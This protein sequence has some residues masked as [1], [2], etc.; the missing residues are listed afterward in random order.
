[1]AFERKWNGGE[2]I[3]A[4][5]IHHAAAGSLAG[6]DRR[7]DRRSRSPRAPPGPRWAAA[8]AQGSGA[9]ASG[10]ASGAAVGNP[11]DETAGPQGGLLA[12]RIVYFDFDSSDIKGE[13]TDV[14]AAH[15]KYLGTN[16]SARIRL[17]GHTDERGSP[18]YN[19]G[20]GERRAQAVRRALL[21][22]GATDVQ[23]T[24]VSYGEERPAVAGHDEAAWAK[25]RRVEIIYLTPAAVPQVTGTGSTRMQ[26]ALI[27]LVPLV[28]AA[29]CATT[30]PEE[31]PLQIKINDLEARTERLERS[32]ANQ[33][34]TAAHTEEIDAQLRELRGRIEELEH[35]A[36]VATKLA[37]GCGPRTGA[38]AVAG[39]A[40][41]G[42]RRT[43]PAARRSSRPPP[44]R[45]STRRPTMRS[46][47]AA[48]RSRSP[49][50]RTS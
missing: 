13:A 47:P 35:R 28:L 44:S 2:S 38:A 37:P 39:A 14:V 21:L 32:L 31:D 19:V 24:T 5:G 50:S 9:G 41:G 10:N 27:A 1:M 8:A 36:E 3:D 15:A 46:R 11:D 34:A 22:Q 42:C 26:R 6:L 43:A 49:A 4:A 30:P 18:E 40:A 33:A 29:G 17:E 12:T 48:T 25:N 7:A 45:R 20:L 16:P 23:I